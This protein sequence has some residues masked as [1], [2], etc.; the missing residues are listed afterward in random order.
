MPAPSPIMT[1]SAALTAI[2]AAG[3]CSLLVLPLAD[4]APLPQ[5]PADPS[6]IFVGIHDGDVL[7]SGAGDCFDLLLTNLIDAPAPWVGLVRPDREIALAEV[8][9]AVERQPAAALVAAQVLRA[10]LTLPFDQALVSESLAYSLLLAS[11]G[12][13]AWRAATPARP[14][15]DAGEPRVALS[16]DGDGFTLR[17]TRAARRNGLDAAMRDELHAALIACDREP[18]L[19][20]RISG[21]GPAFCA[22]GDLDEFGT[23]RDVGMAHLVRVLRSPS[24]AVWERRERI[25]VMLHGACV[26]AGIE[27]PAAASRVIAHP[28]AQL[29]LPEVPMGLIPGAGGTATIA[30]RIGRHRAAF[31]ALTARAIDAATALRW[32]LVDAV[33]TDH[34]T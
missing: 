29:R 22:G 34:A 2:V 21:D 1:D 31:M 33:M 24:R 25:S 32:G 10:S 9:E 12:F 27:F 4:G 15:R 23:A 20:I 18:A 7:P 30:R 11:G 26:G 3:G 16:R 8:E 6:A 14:L 28:G 19:P 13:A 5:L 17:L